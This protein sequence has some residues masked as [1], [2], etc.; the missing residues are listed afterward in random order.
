MTDSRA[1][2]LRILNEILGK[3][4]PFQLSPDISS[5]DRPF[6]RM[7]IMTSLRHLIYIEQVI[8][9]FSSQKN[10]KPATLKYILILGTA[11]LLYMQSPDYAVINSYVNITKKQSN[12]F[13]AGFVNAVLRNISRNK[14][15]LQQSD[16]GKFFSPSFR[17]LLQS[18]YSD[19]TINQIEK[20][21]S[22]EPFLDITILDS[23][24][25]LNYLGKTLP[26]GTLRLKHK[27]RIE[28]LP[29]YNEG[30]W[31]VQDFSSALPVK[32]LGDI[33]GKK[34]LDLC[35]APGGKT[36]QLLA[37]G[38]IVTAIDISSSRLQTLQQNLHRLHLQAEN[39]ICSDAIEFL[40]SV[41]QKY[42]IILLDA[43]C[44]ATGTIRR[45]PEIAHLKTTQDIIKQSLLQKQI[46]E[47]SS[48]A[49][50]PHGTLLYCTC[51]LCYEEGEQ[52]INNFLSNHPEFNIINLAPKLPDE[53]KILANSQ[54]FIRILPNHL[55]S[56]GYADGFFIAAIKLS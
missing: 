37:A 8:S 14:N 6:I 21:S 34:V 12:R 7:L 9:N 24:S 25:P 23:S 50:M 13:S 33:K 35:A 4:Q 2:S 51:S 56:Y 36:A 49:L 40:N 10:L 32:M 41:S 27:G 54:G 55:E 48:K 39:I 5:T 44:S 16:Q 31:W 30:T 52:Q 3:Q 28:E 26:L 29:D 42:D 38:A 47:L 22:T 11:E 17:Q 18:S 19:E 20:S 15:K 45:H 46:L 53:L 1:I 43:P